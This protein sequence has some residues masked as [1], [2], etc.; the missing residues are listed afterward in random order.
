[1]AEI[2]KYVSRNGDNPTYSTDLER[3]SDA[4]IASLAGLGFLNN[5]KIIGG[6]WDGTS[7]K[8]LNVGYLYFNGKLWGFPASMTQYTEGYL[9]AV[10][11][12]DADSTK[13]VTSGATK[14]EYQQRIKY[15][16]VVEQTRIDDVSNADGTGKWFVGHISSRLMDLRE[17]RYGI[18]NGKSA[19]LQ[20]LAGEALALHS[21]TSQ[22]L[23][24]PHYV[25]SIGSTIITIPS[26]QATSYL[27]SDLVENDAGRDLAW[28]KQIKLSTDATLSISTVE[29]IS[30]DS[31]PDFIPLYIINPRGIETSISVHITDGLGATTIEIPRNNRCILQFQKQVDK[32]TNA[33][34]YFL[35]SITYRGVM[36]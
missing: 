14:I 26:S 18:I 30:A 32:T 17:L 10:A 15:T 34:G 25:C 3:L 28:T 7:A 24:L 19:F 11:E 2:T 21:I 29:Q 13:T 35:S 6:D 20:S 1:M 27:L 12:W 33:V 4:T 5:G 22:Q 8:I 9:Y 16:Q 23:L 36:A 31:A